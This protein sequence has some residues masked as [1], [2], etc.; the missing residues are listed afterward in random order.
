MTGGY[1]L[2][3]DSFAGGGGASTGIE[4]ALGRSPDLAINH[5]EKALA[6][7]IANH[8]ETHHV[9]ENIWNID[10][11][12][13]IGD[14]PVGLAWFSPDC[15][16]FSKAKG[17]KPVDKNIRDLAWVIPAWAERVNPRIIMLENVEEF[18]DWGPLKSDNKPD[19]A[20]KGETFRAWVGRLRAQGYTAEWRELRACD[21]GAPT[22]RKRLFVIARRDGKPIVWPAPTHG[23]PNCDAV[24]NGHLKPWRTAA[25]IIDWSLPCPSIFDTSEDIMALYGIRAKRPLEPAT[26]RRI[27]HGIKRFVIDA[28]HPFFISYAQHGGRSRSGFDP[29]HTITASP[30]DQNCL[31]APFVLPITQNGKGTRPDEP[32]QTVMASAPKFSLVA[33]FLAQHNTGVIG[34]DAGEPVSTLTARGTQQNLVSASLIQLRGSARDGGPGTSP[35]WTQTAGGQHTGLVAAFLS[36]YYGQGT[37]ADLATPCHTDTTKDRF[38]LITLTIAGQTYT[39]ADIGMRM[40]TPRERFRAQ[41]FPDSY[42]IETGTLPNGKRISL[43]KTDQGRMCGNSVCPPLAAALVRANAADLASPNIPQP[44]AKESAF[45]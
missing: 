11:L 10:P 1:E 12:K 38:S 34:R 28:E 42:E 45:A 29:L 13:V 27:A 24:K 40:L 25:E 16:H 15:K 36:K 17:T 20:R 26:L 7:H 18:Q 39:I 21:Y 6:M 4:M 30:K 8:P 33:A 35:V 32:I 23:D 43:G 41:G 37:G 2:I 14:R 19:P 44:S 22:I 5:D 31:I 9:S 3:T